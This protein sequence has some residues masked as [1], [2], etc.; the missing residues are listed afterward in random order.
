[1]NADSK[2]YWRSIDRLL[3]SPAVAEEL[4]QEFPDGASLPPE[5]VSRR[6]MLGLLGASFALAGLTG[7]RRPVEAIIP[8]VRSPEDRVPG[9]PEHYATVMELGTASYGLLVQSHQGRPTKIE[10]NELHPASLGAASGWS[11]AALL[12]LYDP[13][14]SAKVLHAGEVA[15]WEEFESF[16]A[17]RRSQLE[18][19]GGRSLL[20][21]TG[22][23]SS[24]TLAAWSEKFAEAYPEALHV[25]A[26]PIGSATVFAGVEAACGRPLRPV[27]HL[28]RART[29]VA[30]DADL[31]L[32]ETDAVLHARGLAA[33]R[34]REDGSGRLYAIESALSN[35]GASADHR[36]A[37]ASGQIPRVA[38][39]LAELLSEEL[40]DRGLSLGL[41][42]PN[43][44]AFP[45]ALDQRLRLIAGDL[46]MAG[47]RALVV[48]GRG[49][50]ESVHTLALAI[51]HALGALGKTV[52]LHPL[53]NVLWRGDSVESVAR[54]AR[55]GELSTVIALGC[56]PLY[57]APPP[58]AEI[59]KGAATTIHLGSH[60]D[61]TAVATTWHLP[62]AHFLESWGDGR[63]PDGTPA[64]QQPLIAPLFAGRSALEILSLLTTGR[65]RGGLALVRRTWSDA[66]LAEDSDVD[67]ETQW[68]RTLHDGA[69]ADGALEAESIELD[70]TAV[71]AAFRQCTR[72]VGSTGI[73]VTVHPSPAVYDGRFANNG[74][75][76]EL[77][78]PITKV[79]WG[80]VAAIAPA[81]AER[82]GVETG[83]LLRLTR[84]KVSIEIPAWISP[85][86]AEDSLAVALGYGR[87]RAGLVGNGVGVDLYPLLGGSD[88]S[89]LAGVT[90]ERTGGRTELAQT[91]EH[92]AIEGRDLVRDAGGGHSAAA[93]HEE[94]AAAA[95][96]SPPNATGG[97]QWGMSIDLDL[98]TGCNGC[99]VACQAEN[100]IPVVGP[101]QVRSGREMHW[102]RI[103][104][105]YSGSPDA[106]EVAFQPL[107]CMHCESAP[108]EEVCPVGATVHDAQGLNAMVYN[109][110]IGTRYCSNNCP[111]KVRRFNFFNF[112]KDLPE[113]VQM[114]MNPDV[115]VRSRGVMEKCSYCVQRIRQ[116]ERDAK[117]GDRPLIDGDVKTACQQTC[118]AEAIQFGDL[119]DGDSRVVEAKRS[120]RSYDLLGELNTRPRTSYLARAR[121]R[122][123][124]WPD[125]DQG[126]AS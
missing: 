15:S 100:N 30:L 38:A 48:A 105:Y 71:A 16:W 69:L 28:D 25:V 96:W 64:I 4:R 62:Q 10:G 23:S 55:A 81:T 46:A 82:L 7:C 57:S 8:Q 59:V 80:N 99:I 45:A 124:D 97:S 51:N 11:Q 93:H 37:I 1:M 123:P 44:S 41:E 88:S 52:S 31:L 43:S 95:L 76:Q 39:R 17:E 125:A 102:L 63:A 121:R 67:I 6:Q 118:P 2:H 101:E 83:D 79:V 13:D 70:S 92:W 9:V 68:N 86:Q 77:P 21:V 72:P 119:S 91:Q 47:D 78:D 20:L 27:Y 53:T 24:P 75:L 3:D 74:W 107:P 89:T 110:C 12:G 126:S 40:A 122:H 84:G 111:Y 35:T 94:A 36:L 61:E 5:G 29:V 34:R 114:A 66:L 42:A 117:L 120:E 22:A 56:N 106:P 50:P 108:C 90:V 33:A 26:E 19:D 32:S 116:A 103:D 87:S 109:R 113:L 14:R 104:R 65:S 115:T 98:C 73:E 49:Q 54:R 58:L 60:V 18:A 112:T 85:G